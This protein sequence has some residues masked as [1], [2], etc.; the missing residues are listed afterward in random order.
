LE[1]ITEILDSVKSGDENFESQKEMSSNGGMK[2]PVYQNTGIFIFLFR[3]KTSSL[4]F[5]YYGS[6]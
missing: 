4:R 6:A 3:K 1:D 2:D 5:F